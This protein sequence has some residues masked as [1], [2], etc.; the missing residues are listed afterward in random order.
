MQTLKDLTI[1]EFRVV[2]GEIVEE[3]LRELLADPDAGLTLRP[4]VEVRFRQDLKKAGLEGESIPAA[5]AAR[6]RSPEALA[7]EL[8]EIGRRCASTLKGP[9]LDHGTLLYDERGLPR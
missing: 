8:L 5:E 1:E 4:V 3:K 2:V 6:R 7:A 9:A